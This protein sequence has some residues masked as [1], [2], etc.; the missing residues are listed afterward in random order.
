MKKHFDIIIFLLCAF[1]T[2]FAAMMLQNAVSNEIMRFILFGI[3][4][5]APSISAAAVLCLTSDIRKH[6]SDIFR[7][8]DLKKAVFMPVFIAC[9][10]MLGAKLI[11]CLISGKAFVLGNIS[12]KQFVIILWALIAEDLGWRGFLEPKLREN[13]LSDTSVPLIVGT[14]WCLWH[15]HYFLQ[16][17]INVPV[18]L[19]LIGC[20]AESYIYSF[21]MKKTGNIL[22]AMIYHF[23]WNLNVHLFLINPADNGGSSIPY[24]ILDII[25]AGTA[26][27]I[28]AKFKNPRDEE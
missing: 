10:T 11:Y 28:T 9:G 17:K 8:E 22:S 19:F 3:Q 20:I 13:R 24:L 25:E 4:A 14:V 7:R 1:L 18:I 16:G 23:M 2:A 15:F 12:S 5:A 21:M 26:L 6:F 27:M